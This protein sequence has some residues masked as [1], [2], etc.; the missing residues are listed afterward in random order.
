MAQC[1]LRCTHYGLII[2]HSGC[3]TYHPTVKQGKS[4]SLSVRPACNGRL[5]AVC[6]QVLVET[7]VA[8]GASVRWA[9]CN[10]YSTQVCFSCLP[11]HLFV[12][13]SV[14]LSQSHCVSVCPSFLVSSFC[15]VC[16]SQGLYLWTFL[17]T[18]V[19]FMFDWLC[20]SFCLYIAVC[21]SVRHHQSVSVTPHDSASQCVRWPR[22]SVLFVVTC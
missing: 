19:H 17:F 22:K 1:V 12:C 4:F 8:L 6:G 21:M 11:V 14:H 15:T 18:Q 16:M 10:I 5:C 13:T 9:A 3:C 2:K 7:L 20:L